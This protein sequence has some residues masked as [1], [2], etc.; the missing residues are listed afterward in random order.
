MSRDDTLLR[1]LDAMMSECAQQALASP[2]GRDSF[3]YGRVS[4]IYGGL[5]MARELVVLLND[6]AD[7]DNL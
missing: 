3:E 7:K 6:E 1:R 5:Y 4:G 2:Q